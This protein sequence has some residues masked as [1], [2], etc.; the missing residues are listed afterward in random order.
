V[1][2][3]FTFLNYI[4]RLALTVLSFD[5]QKKEPKKSAVPQSLWRGAARPAARL[6]QV[7]AL[8]APPRTFYLT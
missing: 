3:L 4:A 5:A 1:K 7:N 2:D 6:A 8:V